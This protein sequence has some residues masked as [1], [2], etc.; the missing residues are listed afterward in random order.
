M[1]PLRPKH[2]IYAEETVST[3]YLVFGASNL[4]CAVAICNLRCSERFV[5]VM[6]AGRKWARAL[7][8]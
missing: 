1:T 8:L 3:G 4:K 6:E 7:S 2:I 5:F